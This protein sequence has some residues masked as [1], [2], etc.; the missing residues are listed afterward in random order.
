MSETISLLFATTLLALGGAGLYLY[1]SSEENNE[2]ENVNEY[3]DNDENYNENNLFNSN[4]ENDILEETY[5]AKNNSKQKINKTKR[6]K[7]A[8]GTKRRY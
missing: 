5:K 8:Y 7:K 3:K 2:D 6:N 4:D 1:K